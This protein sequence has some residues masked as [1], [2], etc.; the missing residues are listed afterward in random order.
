MVAY[1]LFFNEVGNGLPGWWMQVAD[2]P[3]LLSALVYGGS[4]LYISMVQEGERS[5]PLFYCIAIP[6]ST[7]FVFVFALNFWN[8]FS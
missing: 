7:F 8:I 6:L 3:M 4:S 2:L 5:M 1:M